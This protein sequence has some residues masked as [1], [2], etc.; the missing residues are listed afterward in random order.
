VKAEAEMSEPSRSVL[1]LFWNITLETVSDPP[2]KLI[3]LS[4]D[5]V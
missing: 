1:P 5:S 3:N 2:P 4:F